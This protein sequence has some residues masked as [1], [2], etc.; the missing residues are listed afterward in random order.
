[1][2]RA[3]VVDTNYHVARCAARHALN[4][5]VFLF[6]LVLVG[7][8]PAIAQVRWTI[9][10]DN[11]YRN[12]EPYFPIGVYY[13]SPYSWQNAQRMADLETIANA[14]FNHIHTH[15][16]LGDRG[17]LDRCAQRGVSVIMEFN[18][19]PERVVAAFK[20]HP[21]RAG[22]MIYD[23]VDARR[24]DG[25]QA[26]SPNQASSRARYFKSLD[27]AGY[28]LLSAGYSS[29]FS[30]Y[31]NRSDAYALMNYPIPFESTKSTDWNYSRAF[32]SILPYNQLLYGIMQS[33]NWPGYRPPTA[34][35]VRNMTYQ[36]L[37]NG[38]KGLLYFG[39]KQD[40]YGSGFYMRN[41]P[42]LWSGMARLPGEVLR[43]KD[44]WLFGQRTRL[45][46]SNANVVAGVWRHNGRAYAV[47]A[48]TN[49]YAVSYSVRLPF[50]TS[51]TVQNTF[52]TRP[53]GLY[54]SGSYLAGRLSALE[55]YVVDMG[56]Q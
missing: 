3:R 40:G 50:A 30:L 4:Q 44:V 36:A 9:V 7:V 25:T 11:L 26:I 51:S 17:F 24:S 22:Y 10:N 6:F 32:P 33:F 37:I 5:I 28:T 47:L 41:S 42:A 18:D 20:N 8:T 43:L 35:E 34:P 54:K 15:V 19:V 45:Y 16:A 21:A 29:R 52:S 14:G 1:M 31:V 13:L 27:P 39:Y 53:G 55:T 12:G 49:N 2:Q 46:G 23:D 38:V 48:N 56:L